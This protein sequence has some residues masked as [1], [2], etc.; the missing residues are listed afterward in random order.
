MQIKCIKSALETDM[1]VI[2]PTGYGKSLVYELIQIICD[3]KMIIISPVNAITDEQIRRLDLTI[4][5]DEYLI[6][7]IGNKN[8]GKKILL[9]YMSHCEKKPM[10]KHASFNSYKPDVMFIDTQTVQ[11]QIRHHTESLAGHI[12][13]YELYSFISNIKFTL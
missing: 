12:T 10:G 13:L 6:K 7:E 11:I 8:P 1:L 2:L 4:K 9:F 5:L 3:S